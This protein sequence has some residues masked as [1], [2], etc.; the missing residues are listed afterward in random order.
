MLRYFSLKEFDSPDLPGSGEL[1]D[2]DFLDLLDEARARADTPFVISSGFRTGE[3]HASLKAQGYKVGKDS[4]HLLGLA[5][6]IRVS[7]STARYKILEALLHVGFD[8]V[9]LAKNFIH[10]DLDTRPHKA[11]EVIWT[12]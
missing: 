5:A 10:V 2:L 8:R 3:H 1:M 9:G 7:N 12:Y 4:A 6:D 11:N